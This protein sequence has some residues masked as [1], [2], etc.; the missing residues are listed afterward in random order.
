M[1]RCLIENNAVASL[2]LKVV[3]KLVLL[4]PRL[5]SSDER[6]LLVTALAIKRRTRK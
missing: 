1:T 3:G 4:I 6:D 2:P 5:S